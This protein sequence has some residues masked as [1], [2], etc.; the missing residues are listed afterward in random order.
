MSVRVPLARP[1]RRQREAG[2]DWRRPRG[3]RADDVILRTVGGVAVAGLVAV[4]VAPGVAPLTLFV[5]YTVWTNG[6]HSP[7]LPASYEPVLMLYGRL[8]PPVLIGAI[9]TIATVFTE[10]INYHLYARVAE[11]PAVSGLRNGRLVARLTRLFERRPF[12]AVWLCSITP[13]PYWSA[14]IL[15]VLTRYSKRKHLTATAMGR[16]PKLWFIAA[17]GGPLGLSVRWLAIAS[18]A[19]LVL[20]AFLW[21]LARFKRSRPGARS[22]RGQAA[23]RQD[24]LTIE[25]HVI[26]ADAMG[27]LPMTSQSTAR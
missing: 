7:V 16:F 27:P 25:R 17:L 18:I 15:S 10:W 26:P 20:A 1:A 22:V 5:L 13:L 19:A 12:F 24:G 11:A 4:V 6:P 21:G 23:A 8:Y 9:G 2:I 3:H 14:R